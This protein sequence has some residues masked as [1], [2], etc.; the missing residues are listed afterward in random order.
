M[1]YRFFTITPDG[2]KKISPKRVFLPMTGVCQFCSRDCGECAKARY[3][4]DQVALGLGEP[5][6]YA[7]MARWVEMT[8]VRIGK[9]G[10]YDAID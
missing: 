4:A 9:G 3:E 10:Q 1:E 8:R 5:G 6:E 2:E 7:V